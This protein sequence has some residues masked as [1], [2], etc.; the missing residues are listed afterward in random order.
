MTKNDDKSLN[1]LANSAVVYE[2]PISSSMRYSVREYINKTRE[3]VMLK[4]SVEIKK[5][6][7]LK[8]EENYK[9]IIESVMDSIVS[10]QQAKELFKE[11]FILRF[12]R[13]VKYLRVQ[14]EK[15]LVELNN[16]LDKKSQLELE[17]QKLE[18]KKS[19]S[20]EFVRLYREYRD[21]LICV[22]ER[23][24]N[25]PKFFIENQNYQNN[26]IVRLENSEKKKISRNSKLI[27][28]NSFDPTIDVD[29]TVD[30]DLDSNID[31]EGRNR[32]LME[33][34]KRKKARN[35]LLNQLNSSQSNEMSVL[36]NKNSLSPNSKT[37]KISKVTSSSNNIKHS[38][39]VLN[40]NSNLNTHTNSPSKINSAA[41]HKVPGKGNKMRSSKLILNNI[42]NPSN[43]IKTNYL[44]I[45][46]VMKN[47]LN[48][49]K[50]QFNKKN[51]KTEDQTLSGVDETIIQKFNKY[52]SKPIYENSND[53]NEDIK[54]MQLENIN[55]LKKLTST[56]S[57]VNILKQ[58][59]QKLIKENKNEINSLQ[60]EVEQR[61]T[62]IKE[63]Q[64]VNKS[65]LEEKN[66]IFKNFNGNDIKYTSNAYPEDDNLPNAQNNTSNI[67]NSN[68]TKK[69]LIKTK[70]N[71]AILYSKVNEIFH[72][73]LEIP[74]SANIQKEMNFSLSLNNSISILQNKIEEKVNHEKNLTNRLEIQNNLNNC[75]KSLQV[76]GDSNLMIMLKIV[77][78]S[79]DF[80]L[81]KQ[82]S[83]YRDP[84]KKI[85]LEK[86]KSDLENKRKVTKA[87]ETRLKDEK[88]R[89]ILNQAIIER[90][91]KPIFL[92]KRRFAEKTKPDEKKISSSLI[93][94]KKE[95][96]NMKDFDI[97]K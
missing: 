33:L 31:E 40:F 62:T 24:T 48:N 76:E 22:K 69:S 84:K 37:N 42:L 53:L 67:V 27:V 88:R 36:N 44:N 20:K 83:Y 45:N 81:A 13:Y 47:T 46:D 49:S 85:L 77:E 30:L 92:P 55:L 9:N 87:I 8:M 52:V 7:A 32:I 97:D 65:L 71:Q 6:T 23:T 1:R 3:V 34:E 70:F 41:S 56:A 26:N 4:H 66:M 15:E 78:K 79:I 82:D 93:N 94:I 38:S 54:K 60:I 59:T 95:E 74:I 21:F 11:D 63:L 51:D 25:L 75:K 68:N 14:R 72:L 57:K 50:V 35:N 29:S 19:V 18:N 80:L 43:V 10:L 58:D 64:E 73:T 90:N 39:K 2:P 16:I 28:N 61:E 12:D 5:E 17:I 86:L 96:S 91:S 89:E